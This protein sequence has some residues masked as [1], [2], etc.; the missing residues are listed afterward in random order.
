MP[1]GTSQWADT[2]SGGD[3]RS[4]SRSKGLTKFMSSPPHEYGLRCA[5]YRTS[6]LQCEQAC[7]A[8]VRAALMVESEASL[9][10]PSPPPE[11]RLTHVR[12]AVILAAGYGSRLLPATKAI[13]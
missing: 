6:T 7:T 10:R 8:Q 3:T 2:V 9:L 4:M 12:K 11:T 13:P 1:Q 5:F